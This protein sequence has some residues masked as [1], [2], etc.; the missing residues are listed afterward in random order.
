MVNFLALEYRDDGGKTGG[1]VV[2]NVWNVLD[3]WNVWNIPFVILLKFFVQGVK[4]DKK[5]IICY[6]YNRRKGY[7]IF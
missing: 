5:C 3:V 2:W 1:W 7:Y 6:T 4:L